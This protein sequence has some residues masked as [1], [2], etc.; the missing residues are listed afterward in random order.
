M[1]SM[2]AKGKPVGDDA[3]KVCI[4]YDPKDGRVVHV[5]GVTTMQGGKNV[6]HAELE[7]RAMTH[8]K[9]FGRSVEGLKSLH[10][11]PSAIPQHG[12]LR[13]NADG[14]G[15]VLS[16]AR[17]LRQVLAEHRTAKRGKKA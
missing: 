2:I 12:G 3:S 17:P 11:P 5:H 6:S 15:L 7:Q 4:L 8:A 1:K 14:S 13:V 9:A 16:H 10:L